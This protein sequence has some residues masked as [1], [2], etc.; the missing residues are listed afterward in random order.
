[1]R[2]GSGADL[3]EARKQLGWSYSV[4]ARALRMCPVDAHRDDDPRVKKAADRIREMERGVRDV[5]GPISVAVE[6]FLAGFRPEGFH[7]R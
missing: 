4:L 3:H 7:D 6:G 2:V 1:V 5:T